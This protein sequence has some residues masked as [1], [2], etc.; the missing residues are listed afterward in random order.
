MI[1]NTKS[2]GEIQVNE[3]SII[4][5]ENGIPGFEDL[6]QF[7][8][9]DNPQEDVPFC[10]LQ[11]VDNT[12]ISFVIINPFVFKKNYDFEIPSSIVE[13]LEIETPEDVATYVIV[14]IPEDINKM[15]ANL[16]APIIINSK[17]KKGKQ[18]VLEDNRYHIKHLILDEM[19]MG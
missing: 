18:V 5:F 13:G 6:T 15:T 19:K 9:V 3:E 14:V 1:L 7:I 17:N 10:W 16:A 2:L 8:I 4:Q 11:S 12:E